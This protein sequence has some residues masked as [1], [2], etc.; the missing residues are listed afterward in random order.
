[1][2]D[3][4]EVLVPVHYRLVDAFNLDP[5]EVSP[6]L[7][8][9][10]FAI[11]EPSTFADPAKAE[12]AAKLR[13]AI[14]PRDPGY[15][16]R[17]DVL[18]D[19][20]YW[21]EAGL[22][23]VLM[24]FGPTGTGKTSAYEQWCA[25]LGIPLFSVKGHRKFE[26]HEAFGQ[27][28]GGENGT[29][30]W[31]DGDVTLAAM[32]GLPVIINE[33]DRIAPERAIIFN[34]VFEGRSFPIPGRS[35]ARITPREGFRVVV[36]ANTNMVEDDSGNYGT[37]SSHDTSVLERLFPV[38]VKY[39]TDSTERKI[40]EGVLAPFD[41]DLL[42]YWFDQEGIKVSTDLGLKTG[43]AVSRAEF[44]DGLIKVA[45]HIRDSSKDGGNTSDVALER[46]MSTRT[47][48]KWAFHSVGHSAAPERYGK[49]ALH[50]A[51]RKCLS[52]LATRSTQIALHM[53]V[54]TVFGI[55]ETLT[56]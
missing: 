13:A 55:K 32:Y 11:P 23:D 22:G 47:L 26:P 34:D 37:A 38:E 48:R 50:L 52:N 24:L 49:S 53:A 16:Y 19:I 15:V 27:F 5:N 12:L 28:V 45:T 36:T 39:P 21:T 56:T 6:D 17:K 1:M 2:F 54:E 25:C 29:T 20:R 46:T 41:D 10:G 35:G 9:Q 33:Y 7:L 3:L 30:P 8:A 42:A 4:S 14:P 31:V 18:S 44:I 43:S 51:L 40:L